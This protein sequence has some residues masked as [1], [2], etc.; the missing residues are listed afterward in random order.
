MSEDKE[1][2]RRVSVWV[3]LNLFNLVETCRA[4]YGVSKSSFYRNAIMR[5][6]EDLSQVKTE[7]R[8]QTS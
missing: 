3:P 7:P 6:L 1:N 4:K 2:G 5:Y 8:G